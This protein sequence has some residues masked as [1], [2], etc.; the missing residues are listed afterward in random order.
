MSAHR[1]QGSGQEPW[2]W[3]RGRSSVK[4]YKTQR[5]VRGFLVLGRLK[6]RVLIG[7]GDK[8]TKA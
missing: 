7:Q 5:K 3:G 6:K 1:D 2:I 4:R 8:S